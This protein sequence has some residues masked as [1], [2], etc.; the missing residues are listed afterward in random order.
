MKP[1]IN[2][3]MNTLIGKKAKADHPITCANPEEY[4]IIKEVRID[5]DV[6]FV[7]GE[8]TMWFGE[9]LVEVEV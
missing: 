9:S 7:R 8:K 5:H 3:L 4:F 1:S 6:V 2:N